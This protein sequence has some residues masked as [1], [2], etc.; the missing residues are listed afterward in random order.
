MPKATC[1][2]PFPLAVLT[3]RSSWN[4]HVACEEARAIAK[5]L[6][7]PEKR[8]I[9]WFQ[10]RRERGRVD[11][12]VKDPKRK[13]EVEELLAKAAAATL[14]GEH[15]RSSRMNEHRLMKLTEFYFSGN[16]YDIEKQ[17]AIAE[18]LKISTKRVEEWIAHILETETDSEFFQNETLEA[19]FQTD[20]LITIAECNVLEETVGMSAYNIYIW[21]ARRRLAAKNGASKKD[22]NTKCCKQAGTFPMTPFQKAALETH[23]MSGG[24]FCKPERMKLG[25]QLG[26]TDQQIR[27]WIFKR[28][29]GGSKPKKERSYIVVNRSEEDEDTASRNSMDTGSDS[30]SGDS[31]QDVI[32]NT[33]EL[34]I[35]SN[36]FEGLESL[37]E[38]TSCPGVTFSETSYSNSPNSYRQSSSLDFPSSSSPNWPWN[39]QPQG[40]PNNAYENC[41][42]NKL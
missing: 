22:I 17:R 33:S 8:V 39:H 12:P 23:Y 38:S 7:L 1:F 16:A 32:S 6:K 4:T 10:S 42:L 34:E 26:L 29:T 25:E 2:K 20:D 15:T 30:Y 5:L 21:F 27:Y 37:L 24:G 19:R 28:R 9:R 14:S 41:D 3:T 36:F 13:A 11:E 35:G 40:I 18:E 31:S